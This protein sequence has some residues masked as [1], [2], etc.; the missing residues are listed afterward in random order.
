[1]RKTAV[2]MMVLMS[3]L[4]CRRESTTTPA[5]GRVGTA[6]AAPRDVT[7]SQFSKVFIYLPLYVAVEKGF[8]ADQGLRVRLV[9]GGGD[10]K[11]FAA[12]ASGQAQFGVA[13]PTFAAIAREKGQPGLVVASIVAGVPFWGVTKNAKVPTIERPADLRNLRIATYTAPST[14]YTLMMTTLKEH[15]S[16]VGNAKVVQGAFGSLLAM[17]DAGAADIAMELEPVVSISTRQGARVVYSYPETYGPFLLTGM[18]TT[19]SFARDNPDVVQRAVNAIEKAV[20]YCH[21]DREGTIAV[22][23]KVFPEL[24]ADVVRE[25]VNRMLDAG[26]IPQHALIEKQAWANAVKLRLE[27]RDLLSQAVAD[28]TID[29]TYAEKS[30]KQVP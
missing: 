10:D 3:L 4:S 24:H 5:P 15:A 23:S 16:E 9:E 13:D 1:M 18:Y 19:E 14:N 8:F 7:I 27:A 2:L 11:T 22:A 29:N 26:T 28:Q 25:A 17:L 20:R 6:P 12:V 21:F 30:L